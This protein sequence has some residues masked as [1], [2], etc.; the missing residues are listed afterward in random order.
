MRVPVIDPARIAPRRW[1][2]MRVGA[3][4]IPRPAVDVRSMAAVNHKAPNP[5]VA[6]WRFPAFLA[7]YMAAS[8]ACSSVR[9][10]GAE[11]G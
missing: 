10:Q 4:L 7:R 1:S 9:A 5:D 6:C 3:G 11:P 8:A 2:S